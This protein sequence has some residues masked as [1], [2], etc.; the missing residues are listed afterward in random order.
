MPFPGGRIS[1]Q[2]A[3][4]PSLQNK[5]E[6]VW[7]HFPVFYAKTAG[8]NLVMKAEYDAPY[9][10]NVSLQITKVWCSDLLGI[11]AIPVTPGRWKKQDAANLLVLPKMCEMPVMVSRQSRDFAGESEEY[12]KERGGDDA[13]EIFQIREYQPGDKLRSIHWKITAKTGDMMV[14]EQSL[15]LGCPVD[16]Y[17]DISV[18][19]KD[20]S[21]RWDYYVQVAASISHSLVREGCRHHMIWYDGKQQDICRFRIQKEEDIYEALLRM[22]HLE[23]E[24]TG[25]NLQEMYRQKYHDAPGITQLEL[26][27]D[28]SLYKNQ[29]LFHR[30]GKTK[31]KH[32]SS[33][34]LEHQLG[35]TEL[36][37]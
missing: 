16:L 13:A 7:F 18:S 34:D 29:E 3:L 27:T 33:E 19:K 24:S 9:A 35:E 31:G 5:T 23:R 12:S 8:G 4:R 11:I 2:V 6:K 17:L 28:L 21:Q 15:P 10:G 30:Y 32:I 37:V 20:K 14:R 22:G 1:V 26:K 25:R 36:V